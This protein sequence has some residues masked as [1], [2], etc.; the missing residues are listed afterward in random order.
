MNGTSNRA[1]AQNRRKN[2]NEKLKEALS[3]K[4]LD[5]FGFVKK[6]NPKYWFAQGEIDLYFFI[7]VVILV[8]AGIIINFSTVAP[9][10]AKG[11]GTFIQSFQKDILILIFGFVLMIITSKLCTDFIKEFSVLLFLVSFFL[12]VL[13][14]FYHTVLPGREGI[15]RFIPILGIQFQP[16][17]LAKLGLIMFIAWG[18]QRNEKGLKKSFI[19]TLFC[20]IKTLFYFITVGIFFFLTFK[21]HHLSGAILMLAIGIVMLFFSGVKLRWFIMFG[22]P[23]LILAVLVVVLIYYAHKDPSSIPGFIP[24]SIKDRFVNNIGKRYEFLRIIAWLDKDFSP[25]GHR[26]QT[27]SSLYSIANGGLFG[28]GLGNSIRK[29]GHLP[30]APNDFIFAI[31]C[32]ELGFFGGAA[33]LALFAFLM[34]RAFVIARNAKNRFGAL[35]TLGIAVQ[36]GLQTFLHVA[37]VTDM[38]PNTGIGLPFISSGG[39]SIVTMLVQMGLILGVS[40]TAKM[41]KD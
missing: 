28:R 29:Y 1:N 38:V 16:S 13:V 10:F 5:W 3:E 25:K 23:L 40:R 24:E 39:T 30:E 33:V 7:T 19:E 21:E 22:L 11:G 26:Y 20:F 37:V 17:E 41:K 6:L 15:K 4:L 31:I 2:T 35:L 12:L 32:E 27:N 8:L 36:V 34:W 9:D 18:A 14:L